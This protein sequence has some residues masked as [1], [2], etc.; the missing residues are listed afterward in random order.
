MLGI[1]LG[2]ACVLAAGSVAAQ[3][4]YV[5][6]DSGG[7]GVSFTS[8][9]SAIT[10]AAPGDVLVVRAGSYGAFTLDKEL[11]IVGVTG[12]LVTQVSRVLNVS[13]PDGVRL[14]ELQMAGL[15]I[16][17]C[18]GPVLCDQVNVIG[19]TLPST[20]AV[21]ALRVTNSSDV[22]FQRS[23]IRGRSATT[24]GDPG[25]R[26]ALVESSRVEFGVCTLRGGSGSDHN[27]TFSALDGGDGANA[28]E[29]RFGSRVHLANTKVFGGNG[30]AACNFFC[31]GQDGY[32]GDAVFVD[33]GSTAVIAGD[34]STELRGG[35]AGMG[36]Q[37]ASGGWGVL[38]RD[39]VVRWS[40]VSI[41]HGDAGV[42]GV[43]GLNS[44]IFV[45]PLPDPTLELIGTPSV[46]QSVLIAMHGLPGQNARL[47]QGDE[48]RLIVD[49]LSEIEK[50]NNRIRLHPLGTINAVGEAGYSATVVSSMAPGWTRIFQG[51]QVDPLTGG[52]DERTNSVFV[53]VR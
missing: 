11:T 42:P 3:S 16:S 12:V 41:E 5:V 40:G 28:L 30:G 27:M 33:G 1:R 14:A 21:P 7:P 13:A 15:E 8:I 52:L 32:G 50:L 10:A 23:T 20:P 22:R 6:D 25:W 2:A 34:P 4:T 37:N 46:G 29:C 53:I 44:T 31:S 49:G 51:L 19:A 45:P 43:N 17:G 35:A 9:Q 18:S 47:Q 36:V 38:A 48:T 24:A 39:S 26:G